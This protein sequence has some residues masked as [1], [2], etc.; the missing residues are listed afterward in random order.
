[1]IFLVLIF[2]CVSMFGGYDCGVFLMIN[3]L[4]L[5]GG[6]LSWMNIG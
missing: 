4:G 6:G 5:F 1:M 2:S 3:W